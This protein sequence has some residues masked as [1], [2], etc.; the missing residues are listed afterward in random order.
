MAQGIQA[1]QKWRSQDLTQTVPSRASNSAAGL[2]FRR[3]TLP[4]S[5]SCMA[6]DMASS[7]KA[8]SPFS[9]CFALYSPNRQLLSIL[10][11]LTRGFLLVP[12]SGKLWQEMEGGKKGMPGVFLL[13]SLFLEW[14]LRQYLYLPLDSTSF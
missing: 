8:C 10:Q 1:A 2:P 5:R 4:R 11:V 3:L 14:C 12:A 6:Q 9:P 7:W 13:P